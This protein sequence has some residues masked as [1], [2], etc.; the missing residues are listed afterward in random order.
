VENRTVS[1]QRFIRYGPRFTVEHSLLQSTLLLQHAPVQ[2]E[3]RLQHGGRLNAKADTGLVCAQA[4]HGSAPDIAGKNIAN[5]T[6]LILSAAMMLTWLGE[7]RKIPALIEAGNEI[8]KAVDTVL[9]NPK[10]R[11]QDLGGTASTHQ[12]GQLAAA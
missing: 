7:Q 10:H 6:S 9:N 2:R 4:Q 12:F 1:Q 8:E 5:P 11:T 3:R